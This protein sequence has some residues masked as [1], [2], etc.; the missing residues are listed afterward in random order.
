MGQL[1]DDLLELSRLARTQMRHERVDLSALERT[2]VQDL[3][4]DR[5]VRA[6]RFVVFE[7][8]PADGDAR[9]IE[10]ALR[11]LLDNAR[12]FT[13]GETHPRVE[14]GATE[15]N[16]LPVYHVRDNGVGFDPAYSDKLFGVFQRLH[17][18]EEFEGTGMGLATV[19]RVVERHGGRVWAEGTVN[20]GATVYFTLSPENRQED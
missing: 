17:A 13:S 4:R 12:K 11:N 14:F 5:T 1:I 7:S 10:V 18:T 15:E 3:E 2:I 6:V 20:G 16:G 8:P 19:Q 9:L